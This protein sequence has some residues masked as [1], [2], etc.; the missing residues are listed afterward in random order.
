[1]SWVAIAV[2]VAIGYVCVLTFVLALLK[3]AKRGDEPP[4]GAAEAA[5]GEER[6]FVREE[7]PE[8][9]PADAEFLQRLRHR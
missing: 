6:R 7:E 8:L 2:L 4:Y 5:T 1:M 9:T 3:A